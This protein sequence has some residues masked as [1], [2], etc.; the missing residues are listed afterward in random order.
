MEG[1]CPIHQMGRQ[2]QGLRHRGRGAPQTEGLRRGSAVGRRHG[3]VHS[4]PYYTHNAASLMVLVLLFST[5]SQGRWQS[6]LSEKTSDSV[7]T[8]E[9]A[10]SERTGPWSQQ[11][12]ENMGLLTDAEEASDVPS[13]GALSRTKCKETSADPRHR[14]VPQGLG[15]QSPG[16]QRVDFESLVPQD[17]DIQRSAPEVLDGSGTTRSHGAGED[18]AERRE[19]S[20]FH[21]PKAERA[22]RKSVI[23]SLLE[24]FLPQRRRLE[25]RGSA[26]EKREGAGEPHAAGEKWEGQEGAAQGQGTP[27]LV[28]PMVEGS[29]AVPRRRLEEQRSEGG[30]GEG[31]GDQSGEGE[32]GE[33]STVMGRGLHVHKRRRPTFHVQRH[34]AR[35]PSACW[36][37]YE[38]RFFYPVTAASEQHSATQA[39]LNHPC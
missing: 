32:K 12:G 38:K 28:L 23:G 3:L 17:S 30:T 35:V 11:T 6:T 18:G 33:G 16:S 37:C 26:G 8:S 5:G 15:L 13:R 31:G 20:R 19:P 9:E 7:S 2:A 4:V 22:V 24:L 10:E 25:A 14:L 39:L 27:R 29:G 36:S 1:K 34:S 21:L